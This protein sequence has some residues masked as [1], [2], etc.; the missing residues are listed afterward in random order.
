MPSAERNRVLVASPD[1]RAISDLF[2]YICAYLRTFALKTFFFTNVVPQQSADAGRSRHVCCRLPATDR[3]ATKPSYT[4]IAR[5]VCASPL[6]PTPPRQG[7]RQ[8]RSHPRRWPL[9]PP[10][11]I[12]RPWPPGP[13]CESPST[14]PSMAASRRRPCRSPIGSPPPPPT[15]SPR[16]GPSPPAPPR[17]CWPARRCACRCNTGA[18]SACRT[19]SASPAPRCSARRCSPP[20]W[21]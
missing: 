10:W 14:S 18:S 11:S 1:V 3:R 7:G 17:C 21:R 13:S 5:W 12:G 8:K 16:S 2:A 15:R 4:N 9:P 6:S 20:C 19:C